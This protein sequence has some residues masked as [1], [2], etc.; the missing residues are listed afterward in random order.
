MLVTGWAAN[1]TR[2]RPAASV[3]VLSHGRL[4]R[5]DTPSG[6]RNDVASRYGPALRHSGFQFRLPRS[7]VDRSGRLD[8]HVVGIDNGGAT[9]LPFACGSAPG[10][11]AC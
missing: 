11:S 1:L 7:L 5:I 3:L 9:L 8:V 10:P 4:V 6:L 2:R